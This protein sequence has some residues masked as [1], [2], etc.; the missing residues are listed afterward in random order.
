MIICEILVQVIGSVLNITLNNI[1]NEILNK[2]E[3]SLD[4]IK[5]TCEKS[6]FLIHI[7]SLVI[8]STLLLTVVS[9]G[10]NTIK[11]DTRK[12]KNIYYYMKMP[13]TKEININN[14]TNIGNKFKD[15]DF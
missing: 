13:I 3:I 8:I 11:Q 12:N 7:I 15:I 5:V 6:N 10:C 4:D 9:I 14:I 1:K 2:T